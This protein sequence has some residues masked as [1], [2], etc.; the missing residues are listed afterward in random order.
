[1]SEQ[2][3]EDYKSKYLEIYDKTRTWVTIEKD[4][5]LDDVD[6]ELELIHKDEINVSY[7]LQLLNQLAGANKDVI[8][9]KRNR[10]Q[11]LFQEMLD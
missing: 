5:I 4:S 6:F 1:M 3:F 11:T 8:A 9:K 2:E 10:F 7:I